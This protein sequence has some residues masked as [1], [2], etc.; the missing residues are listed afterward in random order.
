MIEG[1]VR[2]AGN[3]VRVTA[4]LIDAL[5]GN[6]LW[7]ERFDRTI[8]DV[9]A[10]QK[11]VTRGIVAAVAPEVELAEVT[12]ARL[13]AQKGIAANLTWRA[14]GLFHE[15]TLNGSSSAVL[16][17]IAAANP[18]L[19]ADPRS[20][21]ALDVLAPSYWTCHLFR[22]GSD[23][24]G[25]LDAMWSVAERMI[26]IDPLDA[27]PLRMCG[28]AR[29][30]RG[31]HERG[32]ADLRWAL[33]AN[34]NSAI[35]LRTLAWAEAR[36]GLGDAAKEHALLAIRLSPRDNETGT[37]YLALA[38]ATFCSRHYAQAANWAE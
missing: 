8:E 14:R 37:A 19:A 13:S 11:E 16:E 9:F 12:K 2:K 36:A 15:L 3:R 31:E 26:Q 17:T 30:F 35:T 6:H 38:M 21:D 24:T 25:S 18:A 29:V 22:W 4:Q 5:T 32:I 28:I 10:V 33:S 1:S 23:P 20:I 7:A 27:R 34:P